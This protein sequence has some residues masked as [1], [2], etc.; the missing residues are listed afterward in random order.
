ML[1]ESLH[2]ITFIQ[3]NNDCLLIFEAYHFERSLNNSFL[4]LNQLLYTGMNDKIHIL[5][6]V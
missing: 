1:N 6:Y 5:M 3:S 4:S 2:K